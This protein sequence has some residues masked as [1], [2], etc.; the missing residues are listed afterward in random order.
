MK[1]YLLGATLLLAD[2]PGNCGSQ[3]EREAERMAAEIERARA[4]RGE[5]LLTC[6]NDVPKAAQS[7]SQAAAACIAAGLARPACS[8]AWIEHGDRPP[9]LASLTQACAAAYCDTLPPPRPQ[10]CEDPSRVIVSREDIRRWTEF[11]AAILAQDLGLRRPEE[12]AWLG[13]HLA[14]FVPMGTTGPT[15]PTGLTSVTLPTPKAPRLDGPDELSVTVML[16]ADGTINID[17]ERLADGEFEARLLQA[18]QADPGRSLSMVLQ[19]DARAPHASVVTIMDRARNAGVQQISIAVES[20]QPA[21][22]VNP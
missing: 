17:G 5:T 4:E 14:S 16:E 11:H 19:A 10:L 15:V 8:E 20:P 22:A 13:V 3:H 7:G 18:N 21:A 12:L 2:V 6:L 1:L 9:F